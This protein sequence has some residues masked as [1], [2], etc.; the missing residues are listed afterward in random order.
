MVD[1]VP[2][3]GVAGFGDLLVSRI[4][5]EVRVT[6][7]KC[8]HADADLSCGFAGPDGVRCPLH[9]SVFDTRDGRPLNPPATEPLRTYNV[10]IDGGGVY[11]E[12]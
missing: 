4:G 10:K 9:L 11:V 7:R 12:Q 6:A 8:T 1:D 2:E 3:G 5:G